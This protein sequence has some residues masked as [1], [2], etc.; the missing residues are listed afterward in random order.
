VSGSD[1]GSASDSESGSV[2]KSSS[3]ERRPPDPRRSAKAGLKASDVVPYVVTSGVA[4]VGLTT[5]SVGLVGHFDP[6]VNL[7]LVIMGATLGGCG[8]LTCAG[9]SLLRS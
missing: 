7:V 8:V 9:L 4:T 3:D 6:A 1:T 2:E 5:M